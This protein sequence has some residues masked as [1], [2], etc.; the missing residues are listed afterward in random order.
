MP[1]SS[2]FDPAEVVELAA[3]W[4]NAS[5]FAAPTM[6]RRLVDHLLQ[7]G[8]KPDGLATI[9]YGGGPMYLADI[10]Q[11]L[12]VVGPHFAQIYGQGESPMTITVCPTSVIE[13][14]EHPCWRERVASVGFA[15]PM[16]ELTSRAEDGRVLPP[17]EPGEVCV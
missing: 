16:V 8:R 11:A 10:Q 1:A 13:D 14:R 12:E 3:H 7:S 4:R 9:T 2:G 15:Q 6:V 5:F 17:G